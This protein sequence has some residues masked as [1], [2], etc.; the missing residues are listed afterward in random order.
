M[1]NKPVCNDIQ[2]EATNQPPFGVLCESGALSVLS[3][4]GQRWRIVVTKSIECD[5]VN[6]WTA[7]HTLAKKCKEKPN[8]D[9][10]R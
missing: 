7:L 6:S 2:S 3:T 9:E 5:R 10:E 4:N 8:G 1:R